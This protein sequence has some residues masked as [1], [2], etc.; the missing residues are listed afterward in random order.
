[1]VAHLLDVTSIGVRVSEVDKPSYR[2]KKGEVATDLWGVCSCDTRFVYDLPWLEDLTSNSRVV[3]DALGKLNGTKNFVDKITIY[4]YVE[5]YLLAYH[6]LLSNYYIVGA[7]NTK[8]EGL[9]AHYRGTWCHLL[10]WIEG[11]MSN[12]LKLEKSQK[13]TLVYLA[14]VG[15]S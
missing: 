12:S 15:Y 14:T 10:E 3:R 5:F 9:L 11:C 8:W 6:L 2:N 7:W 1:M 13:D 4:N